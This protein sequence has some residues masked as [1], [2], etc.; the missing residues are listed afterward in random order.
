MGELEKRLARLEAMAQQLSTEPESARQKWLG[1]YET[2]FDAWARGLSV[3]D[4]SQD[5]ADAELWRATE[6]YAPI[7]MGMIWEGILPGREELLAA[8]ADFSRAEDCSDIVGGRV[9]PR[10]EMLSKAP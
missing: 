5:D 3:E 9:N 7:V 2:Y 8:G 1:L 6:L 10:P 4:I